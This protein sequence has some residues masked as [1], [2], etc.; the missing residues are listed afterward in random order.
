MAMRRQPY[1]RV[2]RN[3]LG[4]PYQAKRRGYST[5]PRTRGVYA[6][7]ENKYF[8]T[9]KA[10]TSIS[11]S[12]NWVGTEY[13]PTTLAT[14]FVPSQGTGIN[15]RIGRAA[16]VKCIKIKGLIKCDAIE[17][18]SN[19]FNACNVRIALVQDTQSNGTQAQGEDVFKDP[20][21]TVSAVLSFQN[22]NNFGRFKVLK[23]KFI[24]LNPPSLSGTGANS[25][26]VNG[27]DRSFKMTYKPK[28]PINVRFNETDGGTIADIVDHSWHII[29]NTDDVEMVPK[30]E[31]QCRVVF[32][33]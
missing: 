23:D 27:V 25:F 11:A 14:L 3:S 10:P 6:T 7:G 18:A 29:A 16:K 17:V 31:Y 2:R 21:S 20:S 8:D 33:E 32:C 13:D 24:T 22:V 15:Q 5:V 1:K 9:E 26:D 28:Q 4:L 30:I 12:S 19:P